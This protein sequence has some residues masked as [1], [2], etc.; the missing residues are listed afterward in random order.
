MPENQLFSRLVESE[1]ALEEIKAAEKAGIDILRLRDHRGSSLLH[2]AAEYRREATALTLAEGYPQLLNEWSHCGWLPAETVVFSGWLSVPGGAFVSLVPTYRKAFIGGLPV[3]S[4]AVDQ[5]LPVHSAAC[6]G[7]PNLVEKLTTM[8][9][10]DIP[11]LTTGGQTVLHIAVQNDQEAAVQ[12]LFK[13]YPKLLYIMDRK[14]WFPTHDAAYMGS[15][16]LL[17]ILVKKNDSEHLITPTRND[18]TALEIAVCRG[19]FHTINYLFKSFSKLLREN[20]EDAIAIN[21]A[22]DANRMDLI[23]PILLTIP[24]LQQWAEHNPRIVAD[25][26]A[27]GLSPDFMREIQNEQQ[28][29][30]QC[31]K[32]ATYKLAKQLPKHILHEIH[33]YL[34]YLGLKN[35][36]LIEAAYKRL[37]HSRTRENIGQHSGRGNFADSV[38]RSKISTQQAR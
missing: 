15:T 29:Q 2:V 12:V 9:K 20:E 17:K 28:E 8:Q 14:G 3:Y 23:K 37:D 11:P 36:V 16:N 31:H 13:N 22:L 18:E 32:L 19:H 27:G 38:K 4:K 33:Q 30:R 25:I 34:P 10:L 6:A 5:W 35:K 1:L 26:A 7:L 21:A 24:D